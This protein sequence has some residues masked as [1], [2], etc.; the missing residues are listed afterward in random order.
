MADD[1]L[2]EKE[3]TEEKDVPVAGII[4]AVEDEHDDAHDPFL[5]GGFGDESLDPEEAD[6]IALGYRVKGGV[7]AE[8]EEDDFFSGDEE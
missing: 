2:E 8:E 5:D 6:A 3:V 1:L 7:T 4:A